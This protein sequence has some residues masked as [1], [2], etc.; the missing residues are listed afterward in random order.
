MKLF[1]N[2][3]H[4][5]A[6]PGAHH[7]GRMEG[8]LNIELRDHLRQKI[9]LNDFEV[10]YVPDELNLRQTIKWINDRASE[11]D[12][13]FSIHFNSH[14]NPAVRG[15]EVFYHNP[16]ERKLAEIFARNV[17]FKVGI[18][19]RGAKPDT[20]TWVGRLGWVRNLKCDSVLV[21]I[22]FLTSPL[23]MDRYNAGKGVAG[24][25]AAIREIVPAKPSLDEVKYN[26]TIEALRRQVA[27]LRELVYKLVRYYGRRTV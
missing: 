10:Q 19:N 12:W 9:G 17:S 2:A 27:A 20:L 14:R 5:N 13:A 22:C 11:K 21:E 4:H 16:R 8:R 26:E 6:D 7:N 18:R 1:I 25:L 23:D 15:T 24:L 3:G